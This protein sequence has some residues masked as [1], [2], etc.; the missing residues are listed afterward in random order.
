VTENKAPYTVPSPRVEVSATHMAETRKRYRDNLAAAIT[1]IDGLSQRQAMRMPA[2]EWLQETY[3]PTAI[4]TAVAICDYYRRDGV[5]I[6][7]RF[8]FIKD[9]LRRD[10]AVP[11]CLAVD[12]G[13][14]TAAVA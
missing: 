1:G 13:P 12:L 11:P 3:T 9:A 7:D 4:W 6:A 5:E 14:A 10:L 8:D 2:V